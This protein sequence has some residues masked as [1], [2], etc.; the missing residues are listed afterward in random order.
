MIMK[1]PNPLPHPLT[2]YAELMVNF[3]PTG[4]I[5]TKAMTPISRTLSN[6]RGCRFTCC[7]VGQS[8]GRFFCCTQPRICCDLHA[9][10]A[11]RPA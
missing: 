9:E 5:P 6:A 2:A 7:P 10:P 8:I 4:M 11:K 1:R 3:C